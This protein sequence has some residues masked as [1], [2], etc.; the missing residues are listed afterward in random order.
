MYR[1]NKDEPDM[2]LLGEEMKGKI[3]DVF[4]RSLA[5]RT[6]DAGSCNGCE[7]ELSSLSNPIYDLERFGL[8]IVA[9]PRHAD[10]LLVT[11]PVTRNMEFPLIKA[12]EA[13]PSPRLVIAMGACACSGGI[14]QDSSFCRKGV[15]EVLPVDVHVP[16]C[17]PRPQAIIQGILLVLDRMERH[18]FGSRP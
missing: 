14:F 13:M 7:V 6:V 11:G 17:P 10:A 9:S 12:Y 8:R 5:I 15:R 18:R 1:S 4:G 16:G 2:A 3:K